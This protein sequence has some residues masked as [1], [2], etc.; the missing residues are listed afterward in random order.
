LLKK[1]DEL[2]QMYDKYDEA[3]KSHKSRY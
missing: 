2:Q 3:L 1:G